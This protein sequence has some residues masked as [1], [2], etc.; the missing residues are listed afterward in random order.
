MYLKIGI[1]HREGKSREKKKRE[2]CVVAK[3]KITHLSLKKFH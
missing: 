2:E 3:F 1:T